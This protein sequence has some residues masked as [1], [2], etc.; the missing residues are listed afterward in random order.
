MSYSQLSLSEELID[1]ESF[2]LLQEY[3]NSLTPNTANKITVSKI[4]QKTNIKIQDAKKILSKLVEV[5]M[6][7]TKY[8]IKCSNCETS[9]KKYDNMEDI[10][11]ENMIYCDVCDESIEVFPETIEVIYEMV[12]LDF[13]FVQGQHHNGYCQNLCGVA[14]EDRLST[15]LQVFYIVLL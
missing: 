7:K 6:L 2:I 10:L 13:P 11:A 1:S 15:F 5:G 14:L 4:I 9:L 3:F 8:V 12:G